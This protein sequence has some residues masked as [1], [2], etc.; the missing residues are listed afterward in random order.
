M[1]TISHSIKQAGYYRIRI[2][3]Q[4][5]RFI[6]QGIR[7]MHRV[8]VP[9]PVSHAT[10]PKLHVFTNPE[11]LGTLSFLGFYIGFITLAQLI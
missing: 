7:K 5:K 2:S 4:I 10:L 6:G 3:S 9:T 1:L 11:A 8:T